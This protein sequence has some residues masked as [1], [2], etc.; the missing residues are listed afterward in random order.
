VI[1]VASLH[2]STPV[3]RMGRLAGWAIRPWIRRTSGTVL[4]CR[5]DPLDGLAQ[6]D[7]RGTTFA[8]VR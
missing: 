2:P 1:I 3:E 5:D 8:A 7:P 4:A 6:T